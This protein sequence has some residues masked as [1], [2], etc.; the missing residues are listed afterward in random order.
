ME[1]SASIFTSSVCK[2]HMG[3]SKNYG[4][5]K[6]SIL[7]GF[8]IINHPFWGT[9]IFGKHPYH[10]TLH[11]GISK[12][13]KPKL[14]KFGQIHTGTQVNS[15]DGTCHLRLKAQNVVCWWSLSEKVTSVYIIC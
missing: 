10:F 1:K 6:S 4:T 13:G 15:N 7:I 9:P 5:P 2:A 12:P 8:S 3:V 11:A 14:S